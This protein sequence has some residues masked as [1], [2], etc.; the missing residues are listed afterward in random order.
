MLCIEYYGTSCSFIVL[1]AYVYLRVRESSGGNEQPHET[2]D[3]D[4]GGKDFQSPTR[5]LYSFVPTYIYV[6][7]G[8]LQITHQLKHNPCLVVP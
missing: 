7:C 2:G 8:A 4:N 6:P 5:N 3:D 1:R